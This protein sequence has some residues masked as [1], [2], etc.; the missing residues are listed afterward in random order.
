MKR[1]ISI[2]IALIMVLLTVPNLALAT[3][4]TNQDTI[5]ANEV[6][7]IVSEHVITC[8]N[9]DESCTWTTSDRCSTTNLY[10]L[11]GEVVAY[12]VSVIGASNKDNGYIVVCAS[13]ANPS[14]LEYGYAGTS[15]K[16]GHGNTCYMTMGLYYEMDGN[17]VINLRD[18]SEH[19]LSDMQVKFSQIWSAV[20]NENTV[21]KTQ[22]ANLKAIEKDAPAIKGGGDWGLLTSLPS[23]TWSDWDTLTNCALPSYYS[24]SDFSGTNNCGPTSGMNVLAYYKT[25]TGFNLLE[26][27]SSEGFGSVNNIYANLYQNM[28][29]GGA[30]LPSSYRTAIYNYITTRKANNSNG[31][32][33]SITRASQSITYANLKSNIN[34]GRMTH[35]VIWNGLEAH[36]INPVSFYLFDS[37]SNVYTRVIDNWGNGINRY[38]VFR[39][40]NTINSA[41]SH[42]G[43]VKITA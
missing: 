12:F 31:S 16:L 7:L 8:I 10:N 27:D 36:Y 34:N 5:S 22:V 18:S 38:Y 14:V 42:M 4:E 6:Q 13:T 26:L 29:N 21:A 11:T 33:V 30:T 32:G 1:S 3:N 43:Y 2:I 25:R 23:G 28:G 41:I 15:P 35:L 19:R 9:N 17:M 20:Q 40:G 39:T 37:N 24:T